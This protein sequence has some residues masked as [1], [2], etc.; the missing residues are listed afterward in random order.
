MKIPFARPYIDHTESIAVQEVLESRWLTQGGKVAEFEQRFAQ[1]IGAKHAIAVSNCGDALD[2]CI[3]LLDNKPNRKKIVTTSYSHVAAV[4]AILNNNYIPVFS[5]IELATYNLDP[6]PKILEHIA[7]DAKAIIV[8]HQYG[9]PI[10][11]TKFKMYQDRYGIE[12]IEDA[13]CALGSKI[14]MSAH[15]GY[16]SKFA[17]FSFHPRKVITTGEGGMIA[18]NSDEIAQ[19]LKI[20]RS[21]GASVSDLEKHQSG[22]LVFEDYNNWGFNYR[23]TDIQAAIGIEQMKKL[24]WILERRKVIADRYTTE[25]KDITRI[26]I[27]NHIAYVQYNWQSYC[28]RFVTNILKMDTRIDNLNRKKDLENA[29]NLRNKV[30]KTLIKSDISCRLGIQPIHTEPYM[31]EYRNNF[32]LLPDTCLASDTTLLLPIYP[33]MAED[34]Q[35]YVIENI[36]KALK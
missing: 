15:V 14:G 16:D 30:F 23:M 10:D 17:C 20:M 3:K 36:K 21:Y 32:T 26:Y 9:N 27:P 11:L 6:N 19:K 25:L 29:I 28:I 31:S 7:H 22:G 4:N 13:A 12:I 8:V 24:D 5:D 18:T 34:E 1:Y 2:M 35:S 33:E